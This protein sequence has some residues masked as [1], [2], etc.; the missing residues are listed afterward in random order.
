MSLAYLLLWPIQLRNTYAYGCQV[1]VT[2]ERVTT[3]RAPLMPPGEVI[4]RWQSKRNY[5]TEHLTCELPI[6]KPGTTYHLDGN[7]SVTGGGVYLRLRFFD[8]DDNELDPI[9]FDGP[10]G[11]FAMPEDAVNYTLELV[12][13]HHEQVVFRY[14]LLMEE[15]TYQTYTFAVDQ[16]LGMVVATPVASQGPHV[17]LV[18]RQT[19]TKPLD[20]RPQHTNL[21]V[22]ISPRQFGDD[23]WI[24]KITQELTA[25]LAQQPALPPS[26]S[27]VTAWEARQRYW[28]SLALQEDQK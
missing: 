26:E 8:I 14:L 6:L 22:F 28:Q 4:H 20:L 7:I 19:A 2:P 16:F 24:K 23:N 11:S 5:Q 9:V 13:T 10:T 27:G 1:T 25:F 18:V 17:S 21:I 3:F 15:T 12:N